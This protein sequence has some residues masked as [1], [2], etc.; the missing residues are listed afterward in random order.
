MRYNPRK[1]PANEKYT[2]NVNVFSILAPLSNGSVVTNAAIKK[3][4]EKQSLFST[5]VFSR[6][7]TAF[8]FRL[9][10]F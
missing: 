10:V 5:Y 9:S 4:T 8:I 1:N 7:I 6:L 3:I 2:A